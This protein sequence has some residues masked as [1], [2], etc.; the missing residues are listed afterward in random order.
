MLIKHPVLVALE[1]VPRRIWLVEGMLGREGMKM[2]EP[3]LMD[4]IRH[5]VSE[6]KE[7]ERRR[8]AA[9]SPP[10]S[11]PH[12]DPNVQR[13][14]PRTAPPPPA[15][16]ARPEA[17]AFW[18]E[19]A[20]N[21]ASVQW[22]RLEA[23]LQRHFVAFCRTP[24][25]PLSVDDVAVMRRKMDALS[26][27]AGGGGGHG[28]VTAHVFA[29]FWD[30]FDAVERTVRRCRWLW[31]RVLPALP[32][33]DAAGR[34]EHALPSHTRAPALHSF[35]TREQSESLLQSMGRARPKP[36]LLRLSENQSGCLT[37]V[38]RKGEHVIY[39]LIHLDELPSGDCTFSIEVEGGGRR[40][41]ATLSDLM[42]A[43]PP[44]QTQFPN[45]PK[46]LI[47]DP[48][49]E[50]QQQEDGDEGEDEEEEEEEEEDEEPFGEEKNP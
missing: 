34:L 12:A 21:P 36:F 47:Y 25:R 48:R 33:V 17:A 6:E 10:V 35:L 43:H 38:W 27:E 5:M 22:K 7:E 44:F 18:A 40:S 14:L 3:R 4:A 16:F 23:P 11:F 9:P 13:L 49:I 41:F 19:C 32:G 26:A 39:T 31:T 45:V 46:H 15:R 30:W 29:R 37:V 1:G 28:L 20:Q 2:H 8:R 50:Q 42:L 24:T